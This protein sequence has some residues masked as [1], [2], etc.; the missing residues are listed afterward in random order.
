MAALETKVNRR[1]EQFQKNTRDMTAMLAELEDLH[2]EVEAG[3]GLEAMNHLEGRRGCCN[4]RRRLFSCVRG[5]VHDQKN[6]IGF[7]S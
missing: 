5:R 6:P 3:G 1:S 7:G 2:A 4:C